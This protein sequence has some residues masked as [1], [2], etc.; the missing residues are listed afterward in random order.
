MQSG[1][2]KQM[3]HALELTSEVTPEALFHAR[4]EF[5][6]TAGWAA[7]AL[8]LAACAR[9]GSGA[10]SAPAASGNVQ[11]AAAGPNSTALLTSAIGTMPAALAH[12]D[13]F[14]SA[15]SDELGVAINNFEQI[16]NYNNYYEFSYDKEDVNPL[17][18]NFTTYPWQLEVAGMVNKP[19]T[20]AIED[21]IGE[22]T[23][24][25]RIYR[26]R[27]VEA[28]SMVIPW[29]GFSLASLLQAVEPTAEAKF[30]KFT[31]V[32]RPEEMPGQR[33]RTLD[34]PYVEGANFLQEA[35]SKCSAQCSYLMKGSTGILSACSYFAGVCKH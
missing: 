23:Q 7:G 29:V 4:R 9:P 12:S 18:Q 11:G 26:L 14:A 32:L 35:L 22:F 21:L 1:S 27:C 19:R 2:S 20:F 5:L 3:T 17:S 34:W 15:A 16:T 31:S 6:R 33:S 25:E 28:W 30:V 8:A 10:S 13:P 24:E